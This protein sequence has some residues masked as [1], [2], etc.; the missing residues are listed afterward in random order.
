MLLVDFP[1]DGPVTLRDRLDVAQLVS[2]LRRDTR[3]RPV[4][5]VS[6]GAGA[7]VPAVSVS[8]LVKAAKG[9]ADIV[10]IPTDDLTFALSDAVG[11]EASVYRGACRVYPPGA[12]WEEDPFSVP[13]RMARTKQEVDDLPGLLMADLRAALLTGSTPAPAGSPPAPRPPAGG[14]RPKPVAAGGQS[15]PLTV[16]T[17]IDAARLAAYLTSEQRNRPVVVLSWATTAATAY[18]DVDQLRSDLAGL[19]TVCEITTLTASWTFSRAVPDRCQVYGGAGRVYPLGTAWLDDPYLS[20]LRFAYSLADRAAVTRALTADALGMAAPAESVTATPA[21]PTSVRGIVMGVVG[22][23]GVVRLERGGT[24]V[25]W[26]ELVE[27]NLPADRV[28]AKD[29]EVSGSFDT[30]S[31]R[32]DVRHLRHKPDT[33]VAPYRSGDTILVRVATIAAGSCGVELFPGLIAT[34]AAEDVIDGD[35][36]DLHSLMTVGETL[37][38]LLVERGGNVDEWLLSLSEAD[39]ASDAVPAPAVLAGGPPWL[40]AADP[41]LAVTPESA[42]VDL[43]APAAEPV[44]DLDQAEV[45]EG[46]RRE[47]AQ[48][49]LRVIELETKLDRAQRD[50]VTARTDRR[51][52]ARH[53]SRTQRE[54]DA[55]ERAVREGRFFDDDKDQLDFELR[56]TWVYQTM[57]AEKVDRPLKSY[58][59]GPNFLA[60]LNDMDG[61]S[62]DKIV[63]V[64]VHVLT[65]RDADL[66]S[67]QLHQLRT[68]TGGDDPAVTRAG[69]EVCW[70]V[71]LQSNT[72]SAR[73]LHYWMCNDGS[74]EFSSIRLHDDYR[75]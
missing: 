2:Y 68:G 12:S 15:V 21:G 18:A 8:E 19:A 51:E 52:G 55:A 6:I 4:A 5:L 57:P 24:A 26:P 36:T 61:I 69:G 63:E 67:R 58:R 22:D 65:G 7:A 40:V 23:R 32:I 56:T 28:F 41:N 72:P 17:E 37:P 16:S 59:Y 9:E 30:E 11:N 45:L 50:L 46:L 34:V 43:P 1:A 38:A 31:R 44:P 53:R 73:R 70:R 20:P 33:A 14:T 74:I 29:M 62:R 35:Q 60:T 49:T 48:L 71:A 54:L 25:V 75:P 64:M 39:D 47:N 66:A 10:V 27:P 42:A 13:L 3:D